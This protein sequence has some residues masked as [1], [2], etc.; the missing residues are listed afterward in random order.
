MANL[1]QNPIILSQDTLSSSAT[2]QHRLGTRAVS[3]DGRVFRYCSA[4]AV[5]LVAGNCIQS[6]AIL[7]NY[8]AMTPSA[9]AALQPNIAVTPGAT[10]AAAG[11]FSEGYLGIDT[12]PGNGFTYQVQ[13]HPAFAGSD[14]QTVTLT[15]DDLVQVALTTASR[16]GMLVN[17]Y[18]NVLQ[19]PVTTATGTLV[20]V[21]PCVIKATQFGWLQTWGIC[22]TL[23]A[24]TPALGA[25][26]LAPSSAAGAAIIMT[27]TNLVVAQLVGNMAQVGVDGKNN[28]VDLRIRP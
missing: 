12:T 21:A 13:S 16:V 20:G 14:L 17:P 27:T 4:G 28:F 6:S 25:M 19:F 9:A 18:K 15:Q 7:T 1:K 24:G 10:V 26:V 11:L 22:S 3:P 8:L 23:I 5:D 2:Q